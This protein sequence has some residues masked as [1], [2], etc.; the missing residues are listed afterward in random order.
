MSDISISFPPWMT[1]WFLLGEAPP[2]T[3]L[4]LISLA[5]AF[6]FGRSTHR[7]RPVHW[8]KL[9]LVIVGGLWL[10]GISF[11]AAGLVDR[12]K[13]DIYQAQH[14]Y[15]LDKAVILA[16]IEIPKGSWISIDEEGI[17][18]AIEAAEDA[19]VPI[20]GALWRGEIRLI[21]SHTHKT[22]DR[23]MIKSATLAADAIIQGIPCRTGT[24]VEFS[25]YGG[26]IQHCTLTQR[27][28]VTAEIDDGQGGKSTKDVGCAADRD[29]WL[30][31]SERRLLERCVLAETATIGTVACAG[32]KEIGLSGDGLDA[33]TL[34]S[35]QRLGP[36]DLS[37]GTL[38]GFSRGHLDRLEMPPTSAPLAIS[39]I[40]VPPGAVVS[41]CDQSW[42]IEWLSVPEDS[43]VAIGGV[44]LTGRMNFDCGK[45]E[46]G[47]LFETTVLG[48]RRLSRGVMV[49]YDDVFRPSSR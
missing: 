31:T 30:R 13:T 29:V 4:V 5:A 7:T 36:F 28:D 46:Y 41:L 8:L 20:D 43:Y 38:V 33:C 48:D 25:E 14:H 26:Y 44:K 10:G 18:Y 37:G 34:A 21:A 9:T 17:P 45:F 16:G 42:G 2:F 39:G 6:L 40:D 15:R 22:S 32:G 47:T 1:A 19:A 27:T 49:S 11:W 3:T 12:I 23:W 35:A 24:L